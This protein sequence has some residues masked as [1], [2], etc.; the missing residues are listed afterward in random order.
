M[1]MLLARGGDAG[2]QPLLVQ[3]AAAATAAAGA[4]QLLQQVGHGGG[5]GLLHLLRHTAQ[6]RVEARMHGLQFLCRVL[7]LLRGALARLLQ[8]RP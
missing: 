7:L 5:D 2:H 4:R 8:V 6:R 3:L 1:K